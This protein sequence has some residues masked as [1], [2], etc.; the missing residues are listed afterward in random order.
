MQLSVG[1]AA[2]DK[3]LEQRGWGMNF[4]MWVM[5]CGVSGSQG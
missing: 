1:R 3:F 4:S 2:G 5:K